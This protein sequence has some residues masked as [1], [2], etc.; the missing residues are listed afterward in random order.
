MGSS[1]PPQVP[2]WI[3]DERGKGGEEEGAGWGG[4]K[5]KVSGT[6]ALI[7]R[8]SVNNST[9]LWR[10]RLRLPDSLSCS[11]GCFSKQAA[12]T[13]LSPPASCSQDCFSGVQDRAQLGLCQN[14][15]INQSKSSTTQDYNRHSSS[16]V[17]TLMKKFPKTVPNS[18][19]V[20]IETM[21]NQCTHARALGGPVAHSGFF[22]WNA[23]NENSVGFGLK[24]WILKSK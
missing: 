7:V 20:L 19:G 4:A 16:H 22:R 11:S 17:Q 15:D 21:A 3:P 6:T 23:L 9:A 24:F 18:R 10:T 2:W 14:Q 13:R 5:E 8:S 1:P 12:K